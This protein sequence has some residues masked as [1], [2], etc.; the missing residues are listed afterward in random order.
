MSKPKN[1]GHHLNQCVNSD[2]V[3][4][5][6][7][8]VPPRDIEKRTPR[9]LTPEEKQFVLDKIE[10]GLTNIEVTRM[11]F[12]K[13]NRSISDSSVHKRRKQGK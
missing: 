9:R 10:A 12:R 4:R 8:A 1:R 3:A 6:N 5:S 13:F 11:F 2:G 7:M